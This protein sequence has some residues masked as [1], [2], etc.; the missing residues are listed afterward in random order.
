[1]RLVLKFNKTPTKFQTIRSKIYRQFSHGQLSQHDKI[2]LFLKNLLVTAA[3]APTCCEL[4]NKGYDSLRNLEPFI[5]ANL[6]HAHSAPTCDYNP[7]I[8][9]NS[10]LVDSK[11]FAKQAEM[12]ATGLSV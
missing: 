7:R 4:A 10:D 12:S 11:S 1:M 9:G 3:V 2:T 5:A 6:R 8:T